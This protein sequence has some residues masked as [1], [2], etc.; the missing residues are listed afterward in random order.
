MMFPSFIRIV[1]LSFL[2][3]KNHF[4]HLMKG[5]SNNNGIHYFHRYKKMF[6]YP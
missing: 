2:K 6:F 1:F 3:Q 4:P 5:V